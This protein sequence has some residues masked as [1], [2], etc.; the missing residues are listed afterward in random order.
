MHQTDAARLTRATPELLDAVAALVR[1][2]DALVL[3]IYESAFEVNAKADASP[4][5][6]ADV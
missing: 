3:S 4:V 6:E 1:E 5:T 2:A